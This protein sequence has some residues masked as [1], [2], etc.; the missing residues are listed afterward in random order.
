MDA[1][2]F[3]KNKE[4]KISK[5]LKDKVAKLDNTNTRL[6]K[7]DSIEELDENVVSSKGNRIDLS[8]KKQQ[9]S[10]EKILEDE[11][12]SIEEYCNSLNIEKPNIVIDIYKNRR[13]KLCDVKVFRKFDYGTC[14][15]KDLFC[16]T[17][18]YVPTEIILRW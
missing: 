14:R 16:T 9:F 18:Y 12:K 13:G 4:F 2:K 7:T 3:I 1:K 10:S 15:V 8:V 6:K 5:L 17:Q 11:L